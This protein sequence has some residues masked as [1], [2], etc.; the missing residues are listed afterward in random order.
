MADELK[1]RNIKIE[2]IVNDLTLRIEEAD[3][4]QSKLIEANKKLDVC[5]LYL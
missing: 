2:D 4:S 3:E 5:F 1:Q